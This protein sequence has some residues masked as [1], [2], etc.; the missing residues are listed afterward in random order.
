MFGAKPPS[1]P[2]LVLWPASCSCLLQRAKIS[3]PIRT[4]SAKCRRADRHDH[5]FLDVDRIVGVRAAVDDV[6]HRHRQACGR[7]RRRHTG[8]AAGPRSSA[9]A[10]ATAR[11]TARIALAPSRALFGVPS[12][13]IIVSSIRP[14]PRRPMPDSA[15]KISPLTAAT[16]LLHALA[17]VAGLVAVAQL[18]RL[19]RAGRGAGGHGGAAHRAAVQHRPPL[20]RSGCPGCRGSRG[21]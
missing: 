6:H 17:A 15:S 11:L 20:P 21:R 3:A 18:D 19:V 1:S 2:T 12:S 14:G 4:A 16:A 10:L 13:S 8:R 9:A 7:R 5:E